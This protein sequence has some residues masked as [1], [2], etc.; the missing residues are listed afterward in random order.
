MYKLNTYYDKEKLPTIYSPNQNIKFKSISQKRKI[1]YQNIFEN[2]FSNGLN[3]DYFK[4]KNNINKM[5]NMLKDVDTKDKFNI[6]H[7]KIMTLY[8]KTK[9]KSR[10]GTISEKLRTN[11]YNNNKIKNKSLNDS[12]N[13]VTFNESYHNFLNDLK[14][15]K[16]NL[17]ITQIKEIS[18]DIDDNKLKPLILTKKT[19]NFNPIINNNNNSQKIL[20][21]N[22]K[23]IYKKK[24]DFNERLKK[25]FTPNITSNLNKL[26]ITN[27][28]NI[29]TNNKKKC[30]LC[31]KYIDIYRFNTHYN[32]HPSKI[33]N[34]LYLGS[35][36]NACNIKDLK[37]LKINYILNCAVE[38]QNKNYPDI[39]YFQ[40]KINDLP[41][42]N[43][44]IFFQK[45][46]NFIQ[47]AKLAG[48]NILIHCQLGI[49]RSTTCL[50]AYMIKFM[51]YSTVTAMQ[52][53][54]NK[55]PHIMPNFGFLQQLKNYE[56]KIK[57]QK[58]S[59]N[60]SEEDNSNNKIKGINNDINYNSNH[61]ND[62]HFNKT[63]LRFNGFIKNLNF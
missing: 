36:Q 54:K 1:N 16:N 29:N 62:F 59:D 51:G 10:Y 56:E 34:W 32:S 7:N 5:K 6:A 40:A 63:E 25:F 35:Y 43:I 53:I 8:D 18:K 15:K 3:N 13:I 28:D 45:T 30:N 60:D 55:R 23:L 24:D 21:N 46:N 17:K 41:N 47:K 49:S 4:H 11:S 50:I 12:Y 61:N 27:N 26:D 58:N 44:S 33:F 20:P 19:N 31:H 57:F 42:F 48:K 39:I 38:C 2:T 14:K 37:D 22:I 9:Y 52:F